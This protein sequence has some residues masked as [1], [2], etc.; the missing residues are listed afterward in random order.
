[1]LRT[2]NTTNFDLTLN[3]LGQ[4][5]EILRCEIERAR[6]EIRVTVTES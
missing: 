2:I 5:G 3:K 4:N 1:M 6:M